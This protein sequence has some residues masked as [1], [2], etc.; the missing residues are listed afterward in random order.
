MLVFGLKKNGKQVLCLF[1]KNTTKNKQDFVFLYFHPLYNN[2]FLSFGR[3]QKKLYNAING[4]TNTNHS[5]RRAQNKNKE[6]KLKQEG[7][8]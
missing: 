8:R 3:N 1:A 7:G 5:T 4:T 6:N 2:C